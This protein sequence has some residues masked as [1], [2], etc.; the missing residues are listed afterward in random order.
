MSSDPL[1]M[2]TIYDR[3]IDFP[4]SVVVRK[5]LIGFGSIEPTPTDEVHEFLSVDDARLWCARRG[6]WALPRVPGDDPKIVE[7]WL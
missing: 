6:L 4:A 2:W 1:P 5:W 3:P 7:T